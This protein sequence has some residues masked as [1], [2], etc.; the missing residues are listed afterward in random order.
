MVLVWIVVIMEMMV[1]AAGFIGVAILRAKNPAAFDAELIHFE[2]QAGL[3]MTFTLLTSGWLVAE[4]VKKY[5]QNKLFQA[6][7]YHITSVLIGSFFLIYKY[8]DFKAK[9]E[10]GL[11]LGK[12]NFWDV[13]WLLAGFHY[14]HVLLGVILLAM[15]SMG[16]K[17]RRFEDENFSVRGSATFWHMCDLAWFFLFALYYI[18]PSGG[19]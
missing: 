3:M 10:A 18:K 12:N 11:T 5:F 17:N 1:F 14:S 6:Q 16:I 15:V 9:A 4:A 7:I 13:Y 19:L 2:L 8:L